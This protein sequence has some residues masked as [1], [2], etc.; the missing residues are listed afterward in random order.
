[1]RFKF[2]I[3][4]LLLHSYLSA[5]TTVTNINSSGAGSLYDAINGITG[6]VIK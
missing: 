4:F 5:Q 6:S 3:P 1:M 2:F